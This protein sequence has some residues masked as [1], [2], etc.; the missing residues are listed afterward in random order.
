MVG[1]QAI[2]PAFEYIERLLLHT[3]F[4][5]LS[6]RRRI[7]RTRVLELSN[8]NG[9]ALVSEVISILKEFHPL[10]EFINE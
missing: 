2:S 4:P 8:P 1:L 10:V 6:L 5:Y 3:E 7:N 9:D